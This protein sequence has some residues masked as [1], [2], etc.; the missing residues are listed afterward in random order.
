MSK[1]NPSFDMKSGLISGIFVLIGALL[2]SAITGYF[3]IRS[4]T[5][6]AEQQNSM[7]AR[8]MFQSDRQELKNILVG[9]SN[10]L[11]DYYRLVSDTTLMRTNIDEFT[12]KGFNFA[13]QI[14]I[15]VSFELGHKTF[16]LNQLLL[17]NLHA[18]LQSKY[19]TQMEGAVAQKA[20]DWINIAKREI[21]LLEQSAVP[22][23]IPIDSLRVFLKRPAR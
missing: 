15:M 5:V 4:Q 8:Q 22:E 20:M 21:R 7:F 11:S 14:S 23:Q 1:N 12:S 6:I 16:E 18:R 13:F 10:V 17:E 2:G 9:Y 3:A 19:K